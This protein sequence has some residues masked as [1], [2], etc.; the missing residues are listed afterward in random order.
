MPWSSRP[1]QTLEAC[2]E[3]DFSLQGR[4]LAGTAL[5]ARLYCVTVGQLRYL[6]VPLPRKRDVPCQ[7]DIKVGIEGPLPVPANFV[8]LG[9]IKLAREP[10]VYAHAKRLLQQAGVQHGPISVPAYNLMPLQ[11]VN[12]Q[13]H[14][15]EER[16][17]VGVGR[18]D[19]QVRLTP[20]PVIKGV[21]DAM[22]TLETRTTSKNLRPNRIGT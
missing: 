8:D 20:D 21:R 19:P 13:P 10:R 14:R 7:A 2:P 1:H 16:P 11:W 5:E 3:A 6:F 17:R 22:I 18:D 4:G 12:L 9:Q 15:N